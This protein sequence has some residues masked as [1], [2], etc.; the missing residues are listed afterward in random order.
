MRA[1]IGKPSSFAF[2]SLITNIAD[3]PSESAE[4]VPAVTVPDAGLN[5]GRSF[6]RPSTVVS[7]R[8]TS[9]SST[10]I[11]EPSAS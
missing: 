5:T 6:D 2:S 10:K 8:I 11:S 4:D 3:A 7:G 1:R 9:S